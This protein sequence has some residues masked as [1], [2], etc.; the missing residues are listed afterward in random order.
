M[1][2]HVD[3]HF[4]RVPQLNELLRGQPGVSTWGKNHKLWLAKRLGLITQQQLISS[5]V[6]DFSV[7]KCHLFTHI[8]DNK[9]RTSIEE[10]VRCWSRMFCKGSLVANLIAL[11]HADQVQTSGRDLP[12]PGASPLLEFINDEN[13][14][15][16]CFWPERWPSGKAPREPFVNEVLALH[17]ARLGPICPD[18]VIRSVMKTSGWDQAL[19][20][21]GSKY[22]ANVEVHVCEHLRSRISAFIHSSPSHPDSSKTC[23]ASLALG[24]TRPFVVAQEDF[25]WAM[26]FKSY[27]GVSGLD[28]LPQSFQ[29]DEKTWALHLRLASRVPDGSKAFSILPVSKLNRKYAYLDSKI[30]HFLI[31]TPSMDTPIGEALR[32]DRKGFNKRRA[33]VR[34]HLRRKY[35]GTKL[36]KKWRKMGHGC[37]PKDAL[38]HSV[39]TD[40][41]GLSLYLETVPDETPAPKPGKKKIVETKPCA[42]HDF[43]DPLFLGVD[44]GRK[45]LFVGTD[46]DG[47]T[48]ILTRRFWY[49]AQR[50]S[51]RRRWERQRKQG[52]AWG[53][54]CQELSAAGGFKNA[55]AQTW[56][57]SLAALSARVPAYI[58]EHIESNQRSRLN[59]RAWRWKRQVLDLSVKKMLL[60]AI[61]AKRPV[62][63]S[64]GDASFPA[65]SRGEQAVPTKQITRAYVRCQK[66]HGI[67]MLLLPV[68]EHNTTKCCHR[69]GSEMQKT[70]T[71]GKD[72]LRYRTCTQCVK[73]R[74]RDVNASRNMLMLGMLLFRGLPRPQHLCSAHHHT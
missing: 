63:L 34:K 60:P 48:T 55:S 22:R 39:E 23:I 31:G 21:M 7:I 6:K 10:Y 16:Q 59:M 4:V 70:R 11:C 14:V 13:R 44:E 72:S 37:L 52:T 58:A 24:R 54:A 43:H 47:R 71:K 5:L 64:V 27:F 25:E 51:Y 53:E 20:R 50:Q 66:V 45:R 9:A 56:A 69:C 19:N 61:R 57:A 74:N 15:K 28:A 36:H 33:Q 29:L 32:L 42:S 49:K 68:S 17:G 2:K 18:S 1:V 35:S 8:Q 12:V 46:S 30:V 40:G 62:V 41:V 3:E 65:T 73:R 38:L 26:S 67:K